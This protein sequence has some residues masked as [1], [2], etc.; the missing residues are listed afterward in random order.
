MANEPPEQQDPEISILE[1]LRGETRDAYAS[2]KKKLASGT[3]TTP[4]QVASEMD[5][6]FSLLV[7]VSEKALSLHADLVDWRAG[8]DEEL[9][10]M[11]AGEEGSSLIPTDALNLKTFILALQH[12]LRASTGPDDDAPQVLSDKVA[13]TLKFIDEI[14]VDPEDEEDEDEE[15]DDEDDETQN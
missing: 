8:V 10:A 2:F 3:F 5:N 15:H 9:D 11:A 4:E 13:D 6:L 12:N 14:T 7:D 1:G